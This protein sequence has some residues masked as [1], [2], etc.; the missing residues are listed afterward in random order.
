VN[1]FD[2]AGLPF[3]ALYWTM[4]TVCLLALYWLREQSNVEGAPTQ[5]VSDPYTLAY[6]RE[7]YREVVRVALLTLIDEGRVLVKG[8]DLSLAPDG[9]KAPPT[10]QSRRSPIEQELL[11]FLASRPGA[12]V[13]FIVAMGAGRSACEVYQRELE[14]L[15]YL[16]ERAKVIRMQ[17]G[18]ACVSMLVVVVALI[19][20]QLAVSRGR[21]NVGF[22]I[23]SAVL[24][25]LFAFGLGSGIGEWTT[26]RGQRAVDAAAALLAGT[27]QR[28]NA[29]SAALRGQELAWIAAAFGFR[30]FSAAA[31]N[32]AFWPALAFTSSPPNRPQGRRTAA[33][34]SSGSSCSTFVSSC[35]GGGGSSCGGGGGASC[36]G[37]GCGGCGGE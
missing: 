7:G 16:R 17:V 22:Q 32:F 25:L 11:A 36:G 8:R 10:L 31:D 5:M 26:T 28:L 19:K 14:N 35:G 12:S 23:F 27:R 37:G 33:A 9:V 20:I 34:G 6:L 2:L 4:V 24:A 1:P 29:A 18:F 21:T 30:V 15:G 3:L 13:D